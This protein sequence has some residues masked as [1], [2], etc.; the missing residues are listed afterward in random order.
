MIR[1]LWPILLVPVQPAAGQPPKSVLVITSTPG[2]YLMA[3]GGT[4][5]SLIEQG[6]AVHVLQV[7][8]DEKNSLGLS[9]ADTRLANNREGEQA[10]R[11][12]GI[13]E[14]YLLNH[15]S[16]E[17]G[18]V[19]SNEIRNQIFG[20][21]RHYKPQIVFHPDPWIHYEPDWDHFFTARAAEE[22]SYGSGRYVGE[23]FTKLGLPPV[24][25]AETYYYAPYRPYRPGEGGHQ[26]AKFRP[27][28]IT[29][30]IHLKVAALQQLETANRRY[31]HEVKQRLEAAGKSSPLLTVLD[32]ASIR[33][34]I[35]AL[36]EELAETIGVKHGFRYGE[37]FNYH[38]A[39][40]RIPPHVRE[41]AKPIAKP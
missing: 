19:S 32:R 3:A 14:V 10:A 11:L 16:G 38:G 1:W 31:A 20:F 33:A 21:V 15:K 27:V 22:L 36:V 25:V 2:D 18:Q 26:A 30:Y 17:L 23:E 7:G 5:A 40:D 35:R 37:E 12:L 34:L 8:N 41:R 28:D 6:Y 9:P 13:R 24:S 39:G 4:L 29:K